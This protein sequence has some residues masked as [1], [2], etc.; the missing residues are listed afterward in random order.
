MHKLNLSI[1]LL[2]Q[3]DCFIILSQRS[4]AEESPASLCETDEEES[5]N[6]SRRLLFL[7]LYC[8]LA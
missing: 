2:K 3:T 8:L 7:F 4:D 6:V 1:Y 5:D